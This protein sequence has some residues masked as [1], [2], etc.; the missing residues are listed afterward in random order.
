MVVSRNW[1]ALVSLGL[2]ACRDEVGVNLFSVQDDIDLGREVRDEILGDPV[3]FPVVEFDD[4]PE[5]YAHLE[6]GRDA[7][8]ASGEVEYA[9]EFD[10]EVY[11]IDDPNTLNAFA[12]PGG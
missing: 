6:R 5:A 10:W 4:A 8:L 9:T 3:A 7:V 2:L 1:I 12:A 11:L